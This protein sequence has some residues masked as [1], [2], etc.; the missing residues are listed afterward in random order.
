MRSADEVKSAYNM[1]RAAIGVASE[2]VSVAQGD[3]GSEVAELEVDTGAPCTGATMATNACMDIIV[4]A[5]VM[6]QAMAKVA[7]VAVVGRHVTMGGLA[8][9]FV[10]SLKR[11]VVDEEARGIE[12]AVM[13]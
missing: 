4:A 6:V 1:L 3:E 2:Q 8:V 12:V 7:A 13:H 10:L 5:L 9:A 11:A